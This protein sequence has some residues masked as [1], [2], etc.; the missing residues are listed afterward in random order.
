MKASGPWSRWWAALRGRA[1]GALAPPEPEREKSLA[2]NSERPPSEAPHEALLETIR[3]VDAARPESRTRALAALA[4]AAGTALEH[5]ALA[6]CLTAHGHRRA[7]AELLCLAAELFTRRGDSDAALRLLE[8]TDEPRGWLLEADLRAERGQPA[9]A[10]QLVERALAYDI[11]T[12]G[13]IDR[14]RRWRPARGVAPGA[15]Q[16]TLL[17]AH[18]PHPTLRILGE[19]GRGGAATVYHAEDATLGR[20]VALKVYHRPDRSR[21]HLLREARMAVRLGGVGVVRVFDAAPEDGWLAMEWAAL[22]SLRQ[23]LRRVPAVPPPFD[24]TFRGLVATLARI[25]GAGYVHADVKPGNILFREDG[26]VLLSDF[27]LSV[28]LG[29]PHLGASRGYVPPDR[30]EGGEALAADDVYA[31]GRVID[32]VLDAVDILEDAVEQTVL[33]RQLAEFLTSANRPRDASAVLGLLPP[34]PAFDGNR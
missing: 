2:S 9:A 26:F 31:L 5:R 28:P 6:A 15:S 3:Q 11:D 20:S 17:A 30:L 23:H 7:P 21:E 1:Q 29:A 22:G 14:V 27:G 24:A 34:A 13:A 19:A 25:H 33:W 4:S 32:E 8:G 18:A 16:P 12:P 10:L